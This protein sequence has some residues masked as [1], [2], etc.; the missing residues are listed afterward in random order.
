M[1]IGA[2]FASAAIFLCG[3]ILVIIGFRSTDDFIKGL[4]AT[5]GIFLIPTSLLFLALAADTEFSTKE[6]LGVKRVVETT[7]RPAYKGG[8]K[9]KALFSNTIEMDLPDRDVI[10]GAGVGS[11]YEMTKVTGYLG[12]ESIQIK[13]VNKQ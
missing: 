4:S 2:I 1:F 13:R 6:S 7:F 8:V 3:A 5:V 9:C 10:D 12:G 11:E